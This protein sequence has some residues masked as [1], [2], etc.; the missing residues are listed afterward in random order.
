MNTNKEDLN[1]VNAF[2]LGNIDDNPVSIATL[3]GVKKVAV[4]LMA[5]GPDISSNLIKKLPE[6]QVHRVG[7][8]ITNQ[9]KEK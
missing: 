6:K 1:I 5:L 8:E 2:D 9:K 7:V 4:L 3:S